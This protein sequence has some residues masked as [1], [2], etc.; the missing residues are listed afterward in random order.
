[1][2]KMAESVQAEIARLRDEIRRHEYLYYV[3]DAPEISDAEYD[4]LMRRLKELEA[5]HPEFA[6]PDSPTV[7]VG[8]APR[9][10]FVKVRHSSPMLSLDNALNE[11]ELADFDRRVSDLLGRP[12]S[13]YVAELKLDGLSM[14]AHYDNGLFRQ[15]VT[16]GDGAEGEDVTENART[17]RSLPLK[18]Q[19]PPWPRFE[20]RGEVIMTRQAFEKL[21]AE[22]A[23]QGLKTYANPRN[24]AAGSLRV[25]DPSI[26]AARQLEFQ[27]YF[28]LVDGEYALASHWQSLETLASMGFKVNP[29][30]RRFESFAGLLDFCREWAEKRDSLPY[31]IDGVV[32]KVDSIAEQRLLGW[33]AK[34]PRWAI[35]Y[36][37]SARQAETVLENIEVQVGRTGALTPVARL[38]PVVVGGVTVSNATLHNE[39]E[40]ARL[41]LAIGDT[42]AVERSGDV[43]PKVV[44]VRHRPADR[45]LFR[46][47]DA[48]PVCGSLVVRAEG[49]VA[50]RC[51]NTDCPARLKESLGHYAARGVMDIDG[52]G[53]AL[54]DQ[55][56]DKGL[57]RGIADLY[58]LRL[59]QL[60]ELERMAE[61]SASKIIA[62]IAASR[63]RP[64]WRVIA[65]L[66][67]PF[68]GERTAQ[69][70]ADHF[71][72][73]D[74][75]MAADE[76]TLQQAEEVGP[77]VAESIRRF[78]SEPHNLE[79]I[80]RLRAAGLQFTQEV[81]R[82]AGSGPFAGMTFVLTGTL[83]SMTREKAKELIE[84]AGGKV[85]GSVSRK[86]SAVVAGEEA[87]SK[88]DKARELGI[89]V[90][91][92][93][94]LLRRLE[95]G[96][97]EAAG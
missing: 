67:I 14:A 89:P 26:T 81:K 16:R 77:K 43:I 39:D 58:D 41:D 8:G 30:R 55:L 27:A 1:M 48:C 56:V 97:A 13:A 75:I 4:G 50:R 15:A 79:L 33:T 57:V 37:F 63:S 22:Q 76:A 96:E 70:L 11:G 6:S 34:A 45:R 9:E 29:H 88:L 61:K 84:A 54:I 5:L 94:E 82:R 62:N 23:A 18:V 72:S 66:G 73:L 78:F 3:L 24:S 2:S 90:W 47:P 52:M 53:D 60:V 21:N 10:G 42:V 49:E 19:N 44:E 20:V 17:I 31:E 59:E 83:P 71:G 38:R 93:A 85:A 95:G 7:R 35:A 40:I 65:G 32:V 68:V 74:A 36:K 51:M 25:L 86:T 64:L 87:G 92:E 69:I 80:E 46:M 91:D 28:L 12:P